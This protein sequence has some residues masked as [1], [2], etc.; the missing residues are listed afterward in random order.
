M[1]KQ[2]GSPGLP[3][4]ALSNSLTITVPAVNTSLTYANA[5]NKHRRQEMGF[6]HS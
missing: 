6:N 2:P 3:L 1:T 5:A 4:L